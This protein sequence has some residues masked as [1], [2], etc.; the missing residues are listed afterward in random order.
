MEVDLKRVRVEC[1]RQFDGVWLGYEL[2]LRLRL[3][4]F[5]GENLAQHSVADDVD[6]AG[7]GTI[8]IQRKSKFER[9]WLE[10]SSFDRPKRFVSPHA[11]T[12]SDK[13][14]VGQYSSNSMQPL[15]AAETH[16]QI[17]QN[18]NHVLLRQS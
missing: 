14:R 18:K 17:P 1:S 10:G 15:A 12:N 16:N 6:G 9:R 13:S 11:G 8:S 2:L 3:I 7:T 4:E 5:L